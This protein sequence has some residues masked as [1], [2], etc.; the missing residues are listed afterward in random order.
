LVVV[1][2]YSQLR[3]KGGNNYI[4]F[5]KGLLFGNPTKYTPEKYEFE[6]IEN[7]NE[8]M[9]LIKKKSIETQGLCRVLSGFAYK[10]N[11]N[12]R[13]NRVISIGND[14]DVNGDG[15]YV[16]SWN[17]EY[18]DSK[19]II[20]DKYVDKVVSVF[21]CQGY[22]LNYAGVILGPDI[23]YD[24]KTKRVD[25]HVDKVIDKKMVVKGN[26]EATKRNVLNQYLV[27]L[28]RAHEK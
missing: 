24:K 6:L 12:V 26:I 9:N 7:P 2:S 25:I 13:K 5:I 17:P 21:A 14:I 4:D 15:K 16:F 22:D 10:F 27:L 8:L 23:F 1:G 18:N 28:T 19:A 3:I 11:N 20:D